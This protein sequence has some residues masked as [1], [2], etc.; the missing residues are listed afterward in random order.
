LPLLAV[1]RE[2]KVPC[3]LKGDEANG[4]DVSGF[5]KVA[6]HGFRG[7]VFPVAFAVDVFGRGPGGG[8]AEVADFE[9]AAEGDED[10]GGF[11]VEMDEVCF[12]DGT[13]SLGWNG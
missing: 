3:Y 8:K 7:N 12:V 11:E 9:G 1:I 10:V 4:K 5:V 6:V 13:D 2:E